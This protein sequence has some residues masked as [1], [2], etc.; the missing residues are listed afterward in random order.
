VMVAPLMWVAV[1][2]MDE[3]VSFLM[4]EFVGGEAEGEPVARRKL[5]TAEPRLVGRC[6]WP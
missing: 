5:A 6:W 2:L 4:G 3:L 1:V